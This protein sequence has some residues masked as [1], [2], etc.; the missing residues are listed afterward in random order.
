MDAEPVPQAGEGSGCF[1]SGVRRPAVGGGA[2]DVERAQAEAARRARGKV[3]RY[4]ASS[5][6]NRLGTLTYRGVG[7][8]DPLELRTDVAAFF[9]A[10]RRE[11]G[12][13]PYL[14]VPE[15]HPGGHGLHVHFAVGR[16]VSQPL[17]RDLWGKGFVH[18]KL[19]G[20][21][22]VGSGALEEAR[23]AA[24]YLSKYVTKNV[25]EERVA[26]LHGMRSRRG[27]SPSAVPCL[28][29]SMDELVGASIGA[30]GRCTGV[31]VAVVGAGRVAGATRLLACLVRL[32]NSKTRPAPG[33][34]APAWTNRSPM[35]VKDPKALD[36]IAAIVHAQTGRVR[37]VWFPWGRG[38]RRRAPRKGW[39]TPAP[40]PG[41][42]RARPAG[43]VTRRSGCSPACRMRRRRGRALP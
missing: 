8:H 4:C 2:P 20:N 10:L 38:R 19:L 1:Q 13:L 41:V 35:K 21:L 36:D 6:L 15:W 12:E 7:C 39:L 40:P 16:Y 14:W 25:G 23:L 17:I 3:R 18:I 11:V 29:R 43:G 24:R 22:P 34:S 31:C 30:D 5:R 28:G 26:R 9:K 33:S 42:R 32:T 37:W 27:F